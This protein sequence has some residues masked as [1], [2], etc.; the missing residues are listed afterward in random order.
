MMIKYILQRGKIHIN[1]HFSFVTSIRHWS[2]NV[3]FRN[4]NTAVFFIIGSLFYCIFLLFFDFTLI[5]FL[6]VERAD[7]GASFIRLYNSAPW[8]VAAGQIK[9]MQICIY[10]C[11]RIL[12]I[13]KFFEKKS[14]LMLKS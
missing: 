11:D 9:G 6:V 14:S 13:L 5:Y 12:F 3:N 2:I 4:D 1:C 10:D 7:L 8:R